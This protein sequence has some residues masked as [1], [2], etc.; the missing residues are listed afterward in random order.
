MKLSD[1]SKTI[2]KQYYFF[3]RDF[4]KELLDD[5]LEFYSSSLS[6]NTLF[7]IIP[8]MA[9]LL[10]IFTYM[11]LFQSVYDKI[12]ALIIANL[13]PTDSKVIMEYFNTFISN[14]GKLGL[15]GFVYII[16]AAIL[17]FKNYDYIVNDIFE[18]PKRNL[19]QAVKTYLG[20]LIVIP[21]MLGGSFYLSSIFQ[22]PRSLQVVADTIH[23]YYFVPYLISWAMFYLTYQVSANKKI[24][25]KAALISSFIASL[26]WH[27]TRS[28]FVLYVLHNST[29]ASIYG[30]ISILLFFFLWIYLSWAIFLHGLR[31]CYLL[32]KGIQIERI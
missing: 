13:M 23:L 18:T 26:V 10:A 17:F 29:Y 25:P 27:I 9:I 3:I 31:F 4:F 20:M 1:S 6:W 24:S 12:E 7:S 21:M 30:G 8:M 11:P 19:W 32:D 22:S 28:G 15:I 5:R 14:S 16:V 2:L